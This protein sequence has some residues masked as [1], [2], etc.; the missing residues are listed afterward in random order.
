MTD[1][2]FGIESKVLINVSF[3]GGEHES[4]FPRTVVLNVGGTKYQLTAR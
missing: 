3:F 2:L 1:E 4:D